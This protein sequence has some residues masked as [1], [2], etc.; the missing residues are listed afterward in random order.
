MSLATRAL[1]ALVV[2]AAA[3]APS[4][5]AGVRDFDCRIDLEFL[6]NSQATFVL[7]TVS[8]L[9]GQ[10]LDGVVNVRING[11]LVKVE[12]VLTATRAVVTAP[13]GPTGATLMACAEID[14]VFRASGNHLSPTHGLK[15]A[16]ASPE[17]G[18]ALPR[19]GLARAT[20][21]GTPIT[22]TP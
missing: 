12:P 2:L 20:R 10:E 18:P 8:S 1:A 7:V 15:C 5:A 4:H 16:M 3:A 21:R 6:D 13:A 19:H 9:H 22:L 17:S 11:R 14:G